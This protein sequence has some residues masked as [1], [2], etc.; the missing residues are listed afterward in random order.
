MKGLLIKDIC[1]ILQQKKFLGMIL[2]L[3]VLLNFS[4]DDIFAVGYLTFLCS[5]FVINS[6]SYDEYENGYRFLFTLPIRRNTYVRSKYVLAISLCLLSWLAGCLIALACYL[7]KNQFDRVQG[8]MVESCMF[9]PVMLIFLAVMI[10]VLLKFGAEKGRIVMAII[11]CGCVFI[12][13]LGAQMGGQSVLVERT[14]QLLDRLLAQPRW[15]FASEIG[16]GTVILLGISYWV[17]VAVMR[18]KE[19]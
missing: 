1:M 18:R 3:S 19:F 7:A 9:L 11:F 6:I 15:V 10:P 4:S 17:S 5:F 12:G 16:A 8:G 2:L 13:Y 14:M